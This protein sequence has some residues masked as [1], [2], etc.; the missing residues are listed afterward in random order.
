MT[1]HNTKN[2]AEL[3]CA[4]FP[5]SVV[6]QQKYIDWLYRKNTIGEAIVANA[7]QENELVG[8]YAVIPQQYGSSETP[9]Q[10]WALSL[11][12]AVAKQARG[13]GLFTSLAK[14][15]FQAAI[16][17]H[18]IVAIVGVANKYSVR[19]FGEKL[20]FKVLTS[21]P[22]RVGLRW[23]RKKNAGCITY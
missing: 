23:P 1:T 9:S 19:G 15:T 3:L 12:T 7:E 16:T 21:L 22:V 4:V 5:G 6:G 20:G 10:R 18:G 11:N 17:E 14:A 13:Q 8:H 2:I